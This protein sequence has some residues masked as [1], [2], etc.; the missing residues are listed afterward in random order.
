MVKLRCGRCGNIWNYRGASVTRCWCSVCN[1]RVNVRT[2]RVVAG[3][4]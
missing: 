1:K 4:F 2:C 3:W